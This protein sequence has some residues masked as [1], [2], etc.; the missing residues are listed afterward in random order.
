M[1]GEWKVISLVPDTAMRVWRFEEAD[2]NRLRLRFS[3]CA[4]RRTSTWIS[5]VTI[6]PSASGIGAAASSLRSGPKR[7]CPAAGPISQDLIAGTIAPWWRCFALLNRRN[8]KFFDHSQEF[9]VSEMDKKW[10]EENAANAVATLP[11]RSHLQDE[12]ASRRKTNSFAPPSFNLRSAG[13]GPAP[14]PWPMLGLQRSAA[15]AQFE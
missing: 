5:T 15:S 14:A 3:K 6:M 1:P 13:H 8:E 11:H 2:K 12:A 4:S 9:Q 7:C 10:L